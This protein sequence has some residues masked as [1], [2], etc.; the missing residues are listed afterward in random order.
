MNREI[1]VR[2]CE[3]LG[4]KFPGPTRQLLPS[5]TLIAS[6]LY[7]WC[8]RSSCSATCRPP[9][10]SAE[11]SQITK[12]LRTVANVRVPYV[13]H[14][15]AFRHWSSRS[16]P[17]AC[18]RPGG[19]EGVHQGRHCGRNSGSFY[20]WS[21]CTGRHWRMC[22]GSAR[23]EQAKIGFASP[24]ASPFASLWGFTIDPIDTC[25][26]EP[27]AALPAGPTVSLMKYFAP[28]ASDVGD[29]A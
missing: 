27:V 12:V 22:C 15:N 17:G 28:S 3:R 10:V 19:G 13:S 9:R 26:A 11:P 29:D 2:I 16:L 6:R 18:I 1:H 5:A 23:S 25:A 14:K 24:V 4:V 8:S 7:A 21:R 20:G